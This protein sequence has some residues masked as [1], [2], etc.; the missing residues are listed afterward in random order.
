MLIL[1]YFQRCDASKSQNQ[2]QLYGG[3]EMTTY[4]YIAHI[5]IYVRGPCEHN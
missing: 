3:T 2:L 1:G 4:V 5:H